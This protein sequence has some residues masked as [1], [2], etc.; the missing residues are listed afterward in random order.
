MLPLFSTITYARRCNL[1]S[2]MLLELICDSEGD[3]PQALQACN[4]LHLPLVVIGGGR[5]EKALKAMAG[6]TVR[7]LGR[8]S[9]TEVLDYIAH[10]RAFLFPGEE[11]FGITPLEAQASGRPVIAYGAGGALAQ[12]RARLQEGRQAQHRGVAHAGTRGHP[13]RWVDRVAELVQGD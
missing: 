7:F 5:D 6:P 1:V 9:D 12:D 10:C 13:R 2:F 8:L 4:K 3:D 11:D